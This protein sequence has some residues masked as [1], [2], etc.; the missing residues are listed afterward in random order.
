MLQKTNY[1][2][3][4]VTHAPCSHLPVVIS[5]WKAQARGGRIG[6]REHS[7]YL[8]SSLPSCLIKMLAVMHSYWHHSCCANSSFMALVLSS[9]STTSSSSSCPDRP[10][11]ANSLL[12]VLGQCPGK[13]TP[14]G[15]FLWGSFLE[16]CTQEK[17]LLRW[18]E[19]G[20]D[21][22]KGCP[23]MQ[24]Q[25]CWSSEARMVLKRSLTLM[26]YRLG[27]CI[28]WWPVNGYGL[29]RGGA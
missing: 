11:D 4:Y 18:K 9:T 5:Q 1:F 3:K 16:M 28:P 10:C 17:D 24:W 14:R 19:A 25:Q 15:I 7:G 12:V 20:M 13:W 2:T 26:V 23:L 6:E 8:F 22:E 29:P 27:L 21:R